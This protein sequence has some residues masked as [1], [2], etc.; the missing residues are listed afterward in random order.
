MRACWCWYPGAEV[1]SA[2]RPIEF[3]PI[4]PVHAIEGLLFRAALLCGLGAQAR[5]L[6][7][8]LAAIT[9]HGDGRSCLDAGS[10]VQLTLEAPGPAR[11]RVGVRLGAPL[12]PLRLAGLVQDDAAR[13][14]VSALAALP[15]PAHA[16]LGTWLFWSAER[17]SVF[18]DLRD[19]SPADALARLLPLLGPR[20]RTRLEQQRRSA[21]SARPWVLRLRAEA[22]GSIGL[23]LHWLLARHDDPER[24]VDTLLPG[25]WPRVLDVYG[26]LLQRPRAAGRWVVAASL[27]DDAD[28]ERASL[29]VGNSG[30]SLVAEDERKHRAVGELIGALGGAR[31]HAEAMW[32]LCRGAAA[33]AWRVGRACE[34]AI[35]HEAGESTPRLGARLFLA[36]QLQAADSLRP[37]P[38]S[39]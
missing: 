39:P 27:D 9:L 25:A 18:V 14:L 15:E 3:D 38:Y 2:L 26:C 23:E 1:G 22:T 10:P 16:H 6:A 33:G 24:W 12:S 20:Q 34:V 36:P 4:A 19:P 11:L 13:R 28:D 17:Q 30:W 7:Q 31:D 29:R 21:G 5:A 35:H 32:S 37:G 8:R